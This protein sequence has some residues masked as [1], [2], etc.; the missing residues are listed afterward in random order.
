MLFHPLFVL[1]S[2]LAAIG[3][4]AASSESCEFYARKLGAPLDGWKSVSNTDGPSCI[5]EP[6]DLACPGEQYYDPVRCK[7]SLKSPVLT[8][9]VKGHPNPWM[10]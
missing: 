1:L 10:L 2:I 4:V 8:T 9:L 3:R 6:V 7:S 5:R